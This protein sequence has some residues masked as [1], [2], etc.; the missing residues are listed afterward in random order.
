MMKLQLN[1]DTKTF[2]GLLRSNTARI[3]L[4]VQKASDSRII[5]DE[6]GAEKLLGA[7]DMLVR[8]KA[9]TTAIRLHGA[10]ITKSD[11]TECINHV[12]KQ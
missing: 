9:G 6:V 3:V 8:P 12:M 1:P 10:S 2:S 4:S 11:I 7:G 5:L